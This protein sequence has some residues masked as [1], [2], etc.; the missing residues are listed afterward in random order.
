[1]QRVAL[2]PII[3]EYLKTKKPGD[4]PEFQALGIQLASLDEKDIGGRMRVVR[5]MLER[6]PSIFIKLLGKDL[7][8]ILQSENL[9]PGSPEWN[10]FQ[11]TLALMEMELWRNPAYAN[12]PYDLTNK[13]SFFALAKG[14]ITAVNPGLN[15]QSVTNRSET[16]FNVI[17]KVQQ[18]MTSHGVNGRTRLENWANHKFSNLLLL[19]SSDFNWQK[20]DFSQL[21]M[22][23]LERRIGDF[24]G[25]KRA[26]E[27]RRDVL[28]KQEILS[29]I[30]GKEVETLAK[31]KEFRDDVISYA[32]DD[33]GEIAAAALLRTVIEFN[34]NRASQTLAGWVPGLIS[35]M[36]RT[37]VMNENF[38]VM[39]ENMPKWLGKPIQHFMEDHKLAGKPINKWPRSIAD[40]V[41]LAVGFGGP[42]ANAWDEY[43]VG[44][45]L[46]G[47]ETSMMFVKHPEKLA[48]MRSRFK[49]TALWRMLGV[50]RKYWWVVP[51]AT[52][53]VALTSEIEEEK[54]GR[55]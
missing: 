15:L 4:S 46:A 2:E 20:T 22:Y 26:E 27:S 24:Q 6:K 3:K 10:S 13:D 39:V 34:R 43:R 54:K 31:I 33:T 21:D 47:A 14:A 1:M 17:D 12:K 30:P 44:G 32:G 50:A 28:T 29:P 52:I 7:G 41:S 8:E 38:E 51:V 23:G 18:Y 25:Q 40:S 19:S 11:D 53:A 55:H 45:F 9:L 35:I 48:R 42:E 5:R 16:Y 37:N 36:R 49:T